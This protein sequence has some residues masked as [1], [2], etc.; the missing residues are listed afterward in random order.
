MA[1]QYTTTFE[2]WP[3][4]KATV[5]L[6][7]IPRLHK[8]GFFVGVGLTPA[9]PYQD[10]LNLWPDHSPLAEMLKNAERDK[11]RSLYGIFDPV[12]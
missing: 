6:V 12:S 5:T 3:E 9:V 4:P 1:L 8:E 10:I 7:V 2:N 11:D